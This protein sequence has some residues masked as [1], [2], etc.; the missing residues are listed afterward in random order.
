MPTENL[1]TP[2]TVRRLCWDW[3]PVTDVAAAVDE[4]LT[5]AGARPWQRELCGAV[6]VAALSQS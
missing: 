3:Q 1:L 6:L 4:F 2:E 5:A